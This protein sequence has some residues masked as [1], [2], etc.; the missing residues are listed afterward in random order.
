MDAG[1]ELILPS[2]IGKWIDALSLH[3]ASIR[4]LLHEASEPSSP[5]HDHRVTSS[6]VE[7]VSLG[8]EGRTWDRFSR[9]H[10]IRRACIRARH[11][12]DGLL[13]RGITPR[14]HSVW[15]WTGLPL[16]G[17]LLVG[18]LDSAVPVQSSLSLAWRLYSHVVRRHRLREIRSISRRTAMFANSPGLVEELSA[19]VGCA[20]QFAPT[21][22]I[23][24][25]EFSEP[26]TVRC[27]DPIRLLFCGRVV[28]DKGIREAISAV[29]IL[30]RQGI[31]CVL[32]VVGPVINSVRYQLELLSRTLGVPNEVRFHGPVPHGP[33]L[34]EYFRFADIF[35]LPTYHE[36]F[37][38]VLWEA[39]AHGCVIITC[40]VGGIPALLTDRVHGLLIA[41]RSDTEVAAA[42]RTLRQDSSLAQRCVTSAHSLAGQYSVE[43]C[44]RVLSEK[45]AEA[46][47]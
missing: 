21:N 29:A 32:N 18:S 25:A 42:V 13:I 20:A 33:R 8:P 17:F 39:A 16:N 40:A 28:E 43:S 37:P 38:H 14:Q 24:A 34:Y 30:R 36:G 3:F 27:G 1:G 44:A 35:V 9:M 26:R 15:R 11:G 12:S 41:P 46:W 5:R 2:F 7:W 22:T 23:S 10:R 47:H 6:K 4:L 45:L 19:R 31:N